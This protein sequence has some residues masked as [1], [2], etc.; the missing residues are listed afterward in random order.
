[1]INSTHTRHTSTTIGAASPRIMDRTTHIERLRRINKSLTIMVT[2][3]VDRSKPRCPMCWESMQFPT[4]SY[5]INSHYPRPGSSIY[6]ESSLI[7]GFGQVYVYNEPTEPQSAEGKNNPD[8]CP[9]APEPETPVALRCGHIFG[10]VC[11]TRWLLSNGTCP[12]C[13]AKVLLVRVISKE[14]DLDLNI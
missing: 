9:D 1:M 4:K 10:R 3:H 13:R 14:R 6:P 12:M 7:E 11:I 8:E 5:G 2:Q